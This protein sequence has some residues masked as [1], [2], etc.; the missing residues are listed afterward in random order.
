MA[1]MSDH[2]SLDE[3]RRTSAI[4]SKRLLEPLFFTLSVMSALGSTM[5]L[6]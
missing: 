6:T 3:T 1:S 4:V 2:L 5:S